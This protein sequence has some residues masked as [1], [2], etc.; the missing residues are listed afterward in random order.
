MK[1]NKDDKITYV[2]I[3]ITVIYLYISSTYYQ[4]FIIFYVLNVSYSVLNND[5]YSA[6]KCSGCMR[7][8][9]V[10]SKN[11]LSYTFTNFNKS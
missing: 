10:L 4:L 3:L 8:I 5:E 1:E 7:P 6:G 2:L 9:K 11:F